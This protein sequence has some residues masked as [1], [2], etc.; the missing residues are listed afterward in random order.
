MARIALGMSGGVDSSVAA[1]ALLDEGHEV[2]GVTLRLG[3]A[4]IRGR[5]CCGEEEAL[6]ARHSCAALGI[7]HTVLD[8]A[9]TFAASV[10]GPVVDAYARGETPNPCVICNEHVKFPLLLERAR[11]LGCDTIATGHYARLLPGDAGSPLV[12]RGT[13]REKD[14]S[15]FLYRVPP[16][17]LEHTHFPIG[18]LTKSQVRQRAERLGLP[19]AFRPDSQDVCFTDDHAALVERV[20]PQAVREGPIVTLNGARVGTHRG[21]ARYTVGQRKGLGIGGAGA[22]WRVVAIDAATA[23]VIVGRAQDLLRDRLVLTSPVWR[24]SGTEAAV[25]VMLRYRGTPVMATAH[26]VD[27]RITLELASPVETTAPGQSVVL[28]RSDA[29]VG[30]GLLASTGE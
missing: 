7:Q 27:G 30:G 2:L 29:V 5:S 23:T 10:T 24:L 18:G 11:A 15:Y 20:R 14:Q 13:D 17:A 1:A 3:L 9:E 19:A 26:H 8:V 4:G 22:P 25:E 21:I 12:G 16:A 6:L 28:Y